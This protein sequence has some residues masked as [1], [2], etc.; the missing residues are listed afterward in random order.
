MQSKV[1]PPGKDDHLDHLVKGK[2]DIS[3]KTKI[4]YLQK[5][6]KRGGINGTNMW[7]TTKNQR[8]FWGGNKTAQLLCIMFVFI[9]LVVADPCL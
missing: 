4:R 7:K 5:K 9:F 2:I 6:K 1:D 3:T 8:G